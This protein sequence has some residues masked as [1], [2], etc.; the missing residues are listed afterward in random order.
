MDGRDIIVGVTGE[1]ESK[2]AW[3]DDGPQELRTNGGSVGQQEEGQNGQSFS[4]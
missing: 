1:W 3:A 4:P 2:V